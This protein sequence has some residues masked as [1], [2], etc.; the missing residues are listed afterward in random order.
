MAAARKRIQ[1]ELAAG[2]AD[3][4][5]I[6][7]RASGPDDLLTLHFVLRGA[8]ATPYEGGVYHG[9]LLFPETYPLAPPGIKMLTPSGRF[10]VNMRLCLSM[11]DYHPETWL[12]T[13][14]HD[15]VLLGLLSFMSSEE[16]STGTMSSP[17]EQKRALAKASLAHNVKNK[18]FVRLFPEYVAEAAAAASGSAAAAAAAVPFTP[19]QSSALSFLSTSTSSPQPEVAAAAAAGGG[20]GGGGGGGDSPS[21]SSSTSFPPSP[22][23]A[24]VAAQLRAL[25]PVFPDFPRPGIN[26]VDVLPLWR[27]PAMLRVVVSSMAASITASFPQP[28]AFLA[29]MESRGFLFA[30]L[31]MEMGLPF[32]CVRE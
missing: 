5:L 16:R 2:S 12:P 9:I 24:E 18:D 15:K 31:A 26:F 30:P 1:R 21:S 8:S 29:G 19:D 3:P 10:E 13:W 6:T 32:V 23:P 17:D 11:S 27:H 14:S 25:L 4:A 22:L 20:G 7:A 28:L